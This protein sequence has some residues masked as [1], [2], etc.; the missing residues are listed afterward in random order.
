MRHRVPTSLSDRHGSFGLDEIP[1]ANSRAKSRPV[2]RIDCPLG[3]PFERCR[4]DDPA[5]LAHFPDDAHGARTLEQ[6]GWKSINGR[7]RLV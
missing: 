3:G 7:C 4:R 2:D 1:A 6:R 5:Q